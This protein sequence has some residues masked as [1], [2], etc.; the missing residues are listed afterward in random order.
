MTGYNKIN[1]EYA[2][3]NNHLL[4]EVLKGAWGYKG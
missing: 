3:G 1:G 2:S 4:N